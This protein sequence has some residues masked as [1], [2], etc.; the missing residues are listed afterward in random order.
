M[1]NELSIIANKYGTDKGTIKPDDGK[2]HGDRLHFTTKYYDYMKDYKDEDFNFLEI[3]IANGTSLK[4]WK[5]FFTKAQIHAMDIVDY[6][7]YQTNRVHIHRA[8][9]TKRDQLKRV[10]GDLK[11]TFIVDDGGH[12]MGQQQISLGCLF[13]SL[14]SG[15]FYFIEDLHTSYWPYNGYSSLYGIPLDIN[16]DRS[17]TTVNVIKDYQESKVF[18]S[19]FLTEQENQYLTDM[20]DECYLFDLPESQYGPNQLALITKK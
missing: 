18:N 15:G 13:S 5:E 9:Q 2:H 3:G 16:K 6:K 4:M 7:K 19:P 10:V 17:N 11:F 20:I 14:K 1:E 8:D 12:M